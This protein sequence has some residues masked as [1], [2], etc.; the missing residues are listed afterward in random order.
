MTD[1]D[2]HDRPA[3]SH[4]HDEDYTEKARQH[5]EARRDARLRVKTPLFAP[6]R[7]SKTTQAASA[8]KYTR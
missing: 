3:D 8:P 1:I 4:W 2:L 7:S 5:A 6:S